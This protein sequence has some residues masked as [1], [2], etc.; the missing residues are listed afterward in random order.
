VIHTHLAEDAYENEYSV[1]QHGCTPAARLARAGLLRPGALLVHCVHLDKD[2]YRLVAEKDCAIVYCPHSNMNNAVGLPDY[3][4]VPASIPVLAGTDGMHANIAA[5][6][7]QL[8]LLYRLQ[9][10]SFEAAFNWLRKIY[11]DQHT[12]ISRWFP[13]FTSLNESDRADGVLWD[14]IPPTP[15]NTDN[16][17]SHYIYGVLESRAHSV[18]QNGRFLLESFALTDMVPEYDHS[19]IYEQGERLYQSISE[20]SR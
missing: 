17:W 4:T 6:Q 2:A 7:K 5:S 13:D 1:K 14:Y 15:L 12:Y 3:D 9:G 8:F 10:N 19:P 16:F 18:I 20:R 11:F